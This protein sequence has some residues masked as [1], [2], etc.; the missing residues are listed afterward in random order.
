MQDR[1]IVAKGWSVPIYRAIE[2]AGGE[3]RV[4]S[5]LG[6]KS[7]QTPQ[8][9]YKARSIRAAY[10][11]PLCVLGGYKVAPEEILADLA[12]KEAA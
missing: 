8:H 9:W 3:S 12:A 11:V 4:A 6:L 5:H 10:I 2:A 1:E 7:S